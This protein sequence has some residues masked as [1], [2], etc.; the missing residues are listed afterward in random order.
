[1]GLNFWAVCHSCKK[2]QFFHRGEE[3]EGMHNFWK[4]HRGCIIEDK[5]SCLIQGDE[6]GEQD[7]MRSDSTYTEDSLP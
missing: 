6:E 7:W 3:S 1:M 2:K 5:N 4:W